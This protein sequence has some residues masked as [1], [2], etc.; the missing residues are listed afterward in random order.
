MN[1]LSKKIR[2]TG[3]KLLSTI[4]ILSTLSPNTAFAKDNGGGVGSDSATAALLSKLGNS[5]DF[6]DRKYDN[7]EAVAGCRKTLSKAEKSSDMCDNAKAAIKDAEKDALEACRKSGM[8]TADACVKKALSCRDEAEDDYDNDSESGVYGFANTIQTITGQTIDKS[9]LQSGGTCPQ[10]GGKDYADRK[11]SLDDKLKQ[12]KEELA[13]LT[14]D[15]GKAKADYSKETQRIQKDMNDEQAELDKQ[16][17]QLAA[18]Q[19]DDLEKKQKE[20]ASM[21][22]SLENLNM[23]KMDLEGK[24]TQ[25]QID[26]A[27][28]LLK[29]SESAISVECLKQAKEAKTLAK[30]VYQ[31]GGTL[32]SGFVGAGTSAAQAAASKAKTCVQT[33]Q[34]ARIKIMTAGDSQQKLI[35]AQIESTANKIANLRVQLTTAS[36]NFNS[37][38]EQQNAAQKKAEEQVVKKMQLATQELQSLQTKLQDDLTAIAE[39]Q[40]NLNQAIAAVN[41]SMSELTAGGKPK[42]GTEQSVAEASATV[43]DQVGIIDRYLDDPDLK[44]CNLSSKYTDGSRRKASSSS[45]S[46]SSRGSKGSGGTKGVN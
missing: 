40:K 17:D 22:E 11:E 43:G 6:C 7:E 16:K 2:Q 9:S 41:Q 35:R 14:E 45:R 1:D 36:D 23:T 5:G 21:A 13:K 32:G 24:L 8:G 34:K 10:F 25:A 37:T 4:F 27:T 3:V 15:I 30:Q 31:K 44:E 46:G 29:Y 26:Q 28:E 38:V 20:Q 12:L 18:Q 39:K 42:S 19:R 33:F